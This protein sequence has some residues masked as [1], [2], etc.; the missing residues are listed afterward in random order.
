MKHSELLEEL[1]ANLSYDKDTG[2]FTYVESPCF[3]L[4]MAGSRAGCKYKDGY[5]YIVFKG[6]RFIEHRLAWHM[7]GF[8]EA[9]QLD[10]INNVKD[11]NRICNLRDVS[12]QQNRQNQ[13]RARRNSKSGI[14]GVHFIPSRNKFRAD[15]CVEGRN[16]S[17]G[18][19]DSSELAHNAYVRAKRSIHEGNTL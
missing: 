16:K 3:R 17:L 7:M 18:H 5:R 10:H 9:K 6:R 15:I 13:I 11:D 2:I 12:I 19:F 1:V 8:E 14:L 4:D